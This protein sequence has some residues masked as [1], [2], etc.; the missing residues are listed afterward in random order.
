[1]PSFL[2]IVFIPDRK[3]TFMSMHF[4]FTVS[5]GATIIKASETPAPRP[6]RK[7]FEG[8]RAPLESRRRPFISAFRPK[9]IPA[10]GIEPINVGAKPL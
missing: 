1:M 6:A 3:G 8:V 10:L 7:F 9:R 4:V 2:S 5:T